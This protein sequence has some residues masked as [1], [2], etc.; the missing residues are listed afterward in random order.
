MSSPELPPR[1]PRRLAIRWMLTAAGSTA[2]AGRYA[3][4]QAAQPGPPAS[5][6][7]TAPVIAPVTPPSPPVEDPFALDTGG[8]GMD[9][10]LQ[11]EYKPG[12]LW[13]LTLNEA[14]RRTAAVL[15]DIIIPADEHSPSASAVGIV[16]FI[17]EWISAPYRPQR[18][19]RK[20]VLEGLVWLD[21]EAMLRFSA[22]F[23]DLTPE[24]QISICDDIC[25]TY[26]ASAVHAPG[27]RF[28]AVFRDLC[29]GGFYSTPQG[30]KDIQYVG[31]VPLSA[32]PGPPP[33]VLKRLGIL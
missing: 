24:Q 25:Y 17:D 33:A 20:A 5:P 15:A 30:W 14:Q 10:D 19:D 4:G 32:F 1:I 18:K 12:E 2:I 11:K 3:W 22:L 7:N 6:T 8:Y 29:A 23:A 28:F 9:P 13:P 21:A 27:A 16:D 31:N 26:R